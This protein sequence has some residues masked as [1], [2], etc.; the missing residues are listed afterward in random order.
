MGVSQIN[1]QVCFKA[2]GEGSSIGGLAQEQLKIVETPGLE[3]QEGRR[4]AD[5][6]VGLVAL[7]KA[8]EDDV[9]AHIPATGGPA[10]DGGGAIR[11]YQSKGLAQQRQTGPAVSIEI[12]GDAVAQRH[13]TPRQIHRPGEREGRRMPGQALVERLGGQPADEGTADRPARRQDHHALSSD[14]EERGLHLGAVKD[15]GNAGLGGL[16]TL[17]RSGRGLT[18]LQDPQRD[19]ENISLRHTQRRG[20]RC[21]NSRQGDVGASALDRLEQT[22]ALTVEEGAG[23]DQRSHTNGDASQREQRRQR[24]ETPVAAAEVF[25]RGLSLEGSQHGSDLLQRQ[26]RRH[27]RGP[28]RRIEGGEEGDA[29]GHRRDEHQ[30]RGADI[31]ADFVDLVEGSVKQRASD[32]CLQRQ[33]DFVERDRDIP[34]QCQPQSQPDHC[35]QQPRE[36]EHPQHPARLH[37]EAAQDGDIGAPL[38][39]HHQLP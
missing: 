15:S 16:E 33:P 6:H 1:G 26:R 9:H 10:D 37:A 17:E 39:H 34:A 30:T 27:L 13:F 35:H 2:A 8:P 24:Q 23:D 32:H 18:G 31:A 20:W 38:L 21:L 29:Q 25:A 11:R 36:Q 7:G 12:S 22:S 28:P 3:A 5:V 4:R 19:V 14:L